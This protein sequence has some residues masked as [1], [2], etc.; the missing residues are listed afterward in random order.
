MGKEK[1]K[2]NIESK[3]ETVFYLELIGVSLVI[4]SLITI[5]NIGFIGNYLF[6]IC[7][8]LFGDWYFLVLFMILING[9][10]IIIFHE[11]FSYKDIRVLGVIFCFL[12]LITFSHFSF[13]DYIESFNR[14]NLKL[15]IEFYIDS[16][17]SKDSASLVGG[18]I[19]GAI[20]FY[21]FYFL[22]GKIG[23]ILVSLVF[24]YVGVCFL[25]QKT[26]IGFGSYF[27]HYIVYF[28]KKIFNMN[29]VIKY[30]LK[31]TNKL[32]RLNESSFNSEPII[33]KEEDYT[34]LLYKEFKNQ[35]KDLNIFYSHIEIINSNHLIIIKL[36]S[37]SKIDINMI[38]NYFK[39]KFIY[40][41]LLRYEVLNN[42]STIVY[43]EITKKIP[44]SY[45]FLKTYKSSKPFDIVLGISPLNKEIRY[46]IDDHLLIISS[47]IND[48]FL[49]ISL[50]I[51]SIHKVN[52]KIIYLS[53]NYYYGNLFIHDN[54]GYL[55]RLKEICEERLIY[56]NNKGCSDYTEYNKKYKKNDFHRMIIL[57]EDLYEILNNEFYYDLYLDIIKIANSVG[58]TFINKL[59]TGCNMDD[60]LYQL[61]PYKIIL[62]TNIINTKT[63][64]EQELL[65]QMSKVEGIYLFKEELVRMSLSMILQ[66]DLKNI[67]KRIK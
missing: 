4:I 1:V 56:F 5:I 39:N 52:V 48:Y 61:L 62:K 57:I 36:I 35:L 43:F 18:G 55:E 7:K 45:S 16:F 15:T 17:L 24:L 47:P 40:P 67:L 29:K 41:F 66:N 22:L 23:S 49:S 65:N 27:V 8:L 11:S 38:Y 34:D 13:H 14:S 53:N 42:N 33:N 26:I 60:L 50:L 10:K 28:L 25:F 37:Y 30:E 63:L 46:K 58:I 32:I 6:L 2:S 9:L 20:C 12:S 64:I 51:Q 44:A 21:L 3:K 54:L 19:I 31:Q 59:S